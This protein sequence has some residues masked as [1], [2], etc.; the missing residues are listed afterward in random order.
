VLGAARAKSLFG[1]GGDMIHADTFRAKYDTLDW[2]TS[3]PATP[4]EL[5][6]KS[7]RK[8]PVVVDP[9]RLAENIAAAVG[10]RASERPA[11]VR[12]LQSLVFEHRI[13]VARKANRRW[14]LGAATAAT[15]LFVTVA[16]GAM[17]ADE[18]L[19]AGSRVA[20]S[21]LPLVR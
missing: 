2:G 20:D 15:L 1:S 16:I 19:E 4:F 3:E 21:V 7:E 13:E 11:G 18:V 8:L 14:A 6:R 12:R 9:K 10:P 17:H 5:T